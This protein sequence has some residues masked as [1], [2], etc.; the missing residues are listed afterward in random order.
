MKRKDKLH[1]KA[2]VYGIYYLHFV[3]KYV[4]SDFVSQLTDV[5]F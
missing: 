5:V 4:K 3:K 1:G 2:K